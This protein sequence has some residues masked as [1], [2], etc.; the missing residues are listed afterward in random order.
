MVEVALNKIQTIC[1][2]AKTYLTIITTTDTLVG[3][4]LN[5]G[6]ILT[7]ITVHRINLYFLIKSTKLCELSV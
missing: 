3:W 1:N 7:M 5:L 6:Y 2:Q 4:D